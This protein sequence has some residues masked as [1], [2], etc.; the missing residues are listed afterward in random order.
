MA[1]LLE[2]KPVNLN[3][4]GVEVLLASIEGLDMAGANKIVAVRE[5]Q[6]FQDS[7]G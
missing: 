2:R 6:H 3:T 5:M 7:G 4:A 1:L